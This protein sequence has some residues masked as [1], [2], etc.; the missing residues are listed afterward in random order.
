MN[1]D[2]DEMKEFFFPINDIINKFSTLGNQEQM[3]VIKIGMDA[4]TT[5]VQKYKYYKNGE[6]DDYI[7]NLKNKH[8][9]E[10]KNLKQEIK[11]LKNICRNNDLKNKE[12]LERIIYEVREKEKF[13]YNT[14]IQTSKEKILILEEKNEGLI[15]EKMIKQQ[16]YYDKLILD[17]TNAKNEESKLRIEY[18]EK[19]LIKERKIEEL[20]E[21]LNINKVSGKKGQVGENWVFNTLVNDFPTF[22][23]IDSHAKGH[24]GDFIIKNQHMTC[25]IESKNYKKNVAKREITKFYKDID[26]NDE[27]NCAILLS[28]ECGVCNKPDFCFEFRSGKPILFL[29]KVFYNPQNIR[30][31]INIFKLVMKN[32]DCFDIAKEETQIKLRAKIKEIVSTHKKIV[33]NVNDYNNLMKEC[34]DKQWDQLSTMFDLLNLTE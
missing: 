16:E 25:M 31:A 1:D 30:I 18:D 12:E 7:E 20:Q 8:V 34:L 6:K 33:S 15:S 29:H 14:E 23:I 28:L 11:G 4:L 9:C 21:M 17:K 26:S 3:E 10:I 2:Y 24:K 22:D 19:I 32:M 13:I 27:Y 5:C